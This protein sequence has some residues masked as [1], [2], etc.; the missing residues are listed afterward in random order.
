MS[1]SSVTANP[2]IPTIVVVSVM[3]L[4]F[5]P[6]STASQSF[7]SILQATFEISKSTTT[8]SSE[9]T[10]L[11]LPSPYPGLAMPTSMPTLSSIPTLPVIPSPTNTTHSSSSP[12]QQMNT[13]NQALLILGLS[14]LAIALSIITL[15]LLDRYKFKHKRLLPF[16]SKSKHTNNNK[17]INPT[18]FLDAHGIRWPEKV[19]LQ[20]DAEEFHAWT[21]QYEKD[22]RLRTSLREGRYRISE[23]G[24]GDGEWVSF[25]A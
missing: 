1:V 19:A 6:I 3:S 10:L 25:I 21:M 11:E 2:T 22:R 8:P 5:D 20:G 15:F 16:L 12:W 24:G 23:G 14:I 9:N 13:A 4:V 18:T 17:N 7:P